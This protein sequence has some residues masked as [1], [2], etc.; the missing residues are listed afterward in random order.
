M[1]KN[2]RSSRLYEQSFTGRGIHSQSV[3]KPGDPLLP[4]AN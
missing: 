3:L 1:Y 2:V 4:N